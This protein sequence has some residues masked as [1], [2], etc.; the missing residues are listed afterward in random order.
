MNHGDRGAP[1]ADLPLSALPCGYCSVHHLWQVITP[2]RTDKDAAHPESTSQSRMWE[3]KCLIA[4][5][6]SFNGILEEY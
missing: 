1:S 4:I 5:L 3:Q 6:Y 2:Q